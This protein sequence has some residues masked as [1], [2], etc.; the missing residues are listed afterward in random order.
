[1]N[2]SLL[3]WGELHTNRP[4]RVQRII[5]SLDR[6]NDAVTAGPLFLPSNVAYCQAQLNRVLLE[7]SNLKNEMEKAAADISAV[8]AAGELKP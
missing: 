8:I 7:V 1:M 2:L 6:F 5:D 4:V 3:S